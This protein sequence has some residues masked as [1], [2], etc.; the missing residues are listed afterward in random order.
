MVDLE[1]DFR[2]AFPE[3]G[4]CREGKRR[5]LGDWRVISGVVHFK[6]LKTKMF[7]TFRLL[8]WSVFQCLFDWWR[9]ATSTSKAES[10]FLGGGFPRTRE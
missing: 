1:E 10:Q 6:Y 9:M 8:F 3:M 5:G 7:L 2:T 4:F